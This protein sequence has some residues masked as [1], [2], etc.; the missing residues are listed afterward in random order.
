MIILI[1]LFWLLLSHSRQVHF[2]EILDWQNLR[3]QGSN[4]F[5]ETAGALPRLNALMAKNTFYFKFAICIWMLYDQQSYFQHLHLFFIADK[6][7]STKFVHKTIERLMAT[8][9]FLRDVI[10]YLA[11]QGLSLHIRRSK[12]EHWRFRQVLDD[13]SLSGGAAIYTT[14]NSTMN[15]LMSPSCEQRSM[16][17]S[18]IDRVS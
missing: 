18:T 9:K 7:P 17:C 6:Q 12:G 16:F 1:M 4:K 2:L 5:A 3:I 13:N 8:C 11:G 10:Q 15:F 14:V